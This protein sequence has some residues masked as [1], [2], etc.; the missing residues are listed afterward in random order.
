MRCATLEVCLHSGEDR[1]GL[2]ISEKNQQRR[3]VFQ[4]LQTVVAFSVLSASGI[5]D[6]H[7]SFIGVR[8]GWQS[9]GACL[10]PSALSLAPLGFA[11]CDLFSSPVFEKSPRLFRFQCF[12]ESYSGILEIRRKAYC[13]ATGERITAF[14]QGKRAWQANRVEDPPPPLCKIFTSHSPY[15]LRLDEH[16]ANNHHVA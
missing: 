6:S 14:D 5:W 7:L 12:W 16:R 10:G 1:G 3:A 9:S 4:R 11:F 13:L 2:G 8:E 15:R